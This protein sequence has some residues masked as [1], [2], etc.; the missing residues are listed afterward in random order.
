MDAKRDLKLSKALFTI[1]Y[2]ARLH[3]RSVSVRVTLLPGTELRP[4]SFHKRQQDGEAFSQKH[5]LRV[6]VS[7]MFP[8]SHIGNIVSSV[9]F[10]FKMQ[11]YAYATPSGNFNENSSM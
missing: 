3:K 4:V 6:H 10:F 8:V 11:H 1:K 7:P 5:S 2:V 9:S